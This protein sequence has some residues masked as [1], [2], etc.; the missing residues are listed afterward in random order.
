MSVSSHI[1]RHGVGRRL[2]D[3]IEEFCRSRGYNRIILS[4]A[5]FLKP[6]LAIYHSNGYRLVKIEPYGALSND[7]VNIRHLAKEM[8]PNN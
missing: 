3:M 8:Y 1:R 4:T 7:Q 5:D 6:A 2:L